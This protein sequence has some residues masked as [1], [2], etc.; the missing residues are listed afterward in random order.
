MERKLRRIVAR[1]RMKLAGERRINK[2]FRG[3][4]RD[5]FRNPEIKQ[6]RRIK[7]QPQS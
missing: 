3:K 7:R 6:R 1:Y 5:Y 2:Y 4:W